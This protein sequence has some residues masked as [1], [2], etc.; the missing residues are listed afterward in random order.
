[1]QSHLRYSDAPIYSDLIPTGQ[2]DMVLSIEPLEVMRYWHY[3]AQDGWV[4]TSVTPYVNIPDYPDMDHLLE[5]LSGFANTIMVDS[6][7]LAK[8]AGNLRAQNMAVVGAA[9][10]RLDFE[11]EALLKFVEALFSRKGE[12]I[13]EV[14][15]R[16]FTYGRAAGLFYRELVDQGMS[17]LQAIKLCQKI[18]PDSFDAAHAAAWAAAIGDDPGLLESILSESATLPSDHL[19]VAG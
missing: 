4:V 13:V 7:L 16:A 1:V 5:D 9:S 11:V 6:G 17:Q 3:L 19:A 2:A 8:A 14:N 18:Q 10:S 15:K 12:K